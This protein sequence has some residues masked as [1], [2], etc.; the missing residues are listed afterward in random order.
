[1]QAMDKIISKKIFIRNKI[2]TPKYS[3]INNN[4]NLLKKLKWIIKQK[5]S[6]FH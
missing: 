5:K 6:T 4:D 2:N 1:M 3:I